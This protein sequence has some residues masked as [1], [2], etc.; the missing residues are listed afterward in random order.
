M[1][2][3]CS[4]SSSFLTF[5]EDLSSLSG[6][7]LSEELSAPEEKLDFIWARSIFFAILEEKKEKKDITWEFTLMTYKTNQWKNFTKQNRL[8]F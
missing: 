2:P 5:L 8:V 1:L 3:C 6:S 7:S 4:S